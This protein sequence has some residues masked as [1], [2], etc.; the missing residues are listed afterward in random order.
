[1][2]IID[3]QTYQMMQR[4][5]M[6][7]KPG[8]TNIYAYGSHKPIT[9]RGK[10]ETTI[11]ASG[12]SIEAEVYVTPAT[13]GNILCCDAANVLGLVHIVRSTTNISNRKADQISSKYPRLCTGIGKLKNY[14]V[15]LHIDDSVKPVAQGH[16]RVP[17][18]LR[19]K[20]EQ[21][22]EKLETQDI[23]ER[24][25]GPTPWI[26]PIVTPPKPNDPNSIRLCVDMRE[27]NKA[28]M[29]ERHLTPT[30]DDIIHDLNGNTIFSKLD[31][32]SGYHQLELHPDS[33]YIT[34]F[35][36]HAGL[37]RYKRLNFG[38]SSASEVFQNTIQT[39]L[40]GIPGVCNISDDIFVFSKP[41]DHHKT[42]DAALRRLHDN[43]L[44]IN[45]SKCEFYQTTI[46][47][48]GY[49]FSKD[50][51]SPD[52]EKVAAVH[53]AAAPK[54]ANEVRSLLGLASY[55]SRFISNMATISDPLRRLT[56]KDAKWH[57]GE[58]EE[59][60][61]Q[62]LKDA[63]T[64]DAVMAYFDPQLD[65]EIEVD[66]SPVGLAGIL[67]QA[68]KVIAYGSRSLTDVETRYSQTEREALA[69]VWACEHFDLY[70]RGNKFK[71]FTD[72]KA[73]TY[74]WKKPRPPLRIE[75]WGLRLQPY[76]CTI[77]YR[78][79]KDNTADYMS[80]H[81]MATTHSPPRT[82]KMAEEYVS[83]IATEAIPMAMSLEE[84]KCA[85]L[86]DKTL[87][88]VAGF[89]RTGRWHD[90]DKMND[91]D[92]DRTAVRSF[93]KVKDELTVSND[94][95][96]I[97]RDTRIVLPKAL[98][99][100]ALDIAHE[101]H[102]G[103]SKTKALVRTKV[104]FPG[105][106]RSIETMIRECLPC[107]ATT[108]EERREPLNMSELPER[109]WQHISMDFCGPL[110]T[111]EYLL[112]IVDEYSRYPVVEVVNSTSAKT[113]IPVV[114]RVFSMFGVPI[115]VKTDNGPPFNGNDFANFAKFLGFRHRKITPLWPQANSQ[116]ERINQPLMKTIR[117]AKIQGRN[118]RQE[119]YKFLRNYRMTPHASTKSAPANLMLAYTMRFKFPQT[120]Y[121]R[122]GHD[123][124]KQHDREAKLKM[125]RYADASRKSKP[126]NIQLDDRVLLR[127]K[128]ENKL[129][130]A[131]D[132]Q[133]YTVVGRKGSMISAKRGERV[134][135]RNTSYFKRVPL[136]HQNNPESDRDDDDVI[137]ELG[138]R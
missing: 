54:N 26:S 20:V 63:L 49:I 61:L 103:M 9:M 39:V 104:W 131:F 94:S 96:L 1:M 108:P 6:L 109:P 98:Q 133:P 37:W 135:T 4:T 137:V 72:H 58:D 43:G 82:Q 115:S 120:K 15:K 111:G 92:I 134:V 23:I 44:T 71:I 60:A 29:R 36:T 102:L 124:I 130:P 19:K 73:L 132:P 2:N 7:R 35:S 97:L 93:A 33:R 105:I 48:Y 83:F 85:T 70:V 76:C 27:A 95:S 126:S 74:I 107:Q 13:S 128:R 66:A 67:T 50:G 68:G 123:M 88:A 114:D 16:R 21:E 79:G 42:L 18:H 30:I 119:L 106:D 51:L 101:G 116:A 136:I 117:A 14:Q 113:V 118:W 125:K 31:L 75:R 34:T 91:I 28:V 25:D 59:Q 69:V 62:K 121:E 17:F 110:P 32:R 129:T 10:F 38:I 41:E 122:D 47:F 99:R 127:N 12:S 100:R 45:L 81:L 80:R 78:P 53:S 46:K 5:P 86:N 55:C 57:W 24:V 52:P 87:Q 65:T 22:L 8:R 138:T 84:V 56:H 3:S 112:V 40:Q 90:V 77:V 64:S 89:I 11:T